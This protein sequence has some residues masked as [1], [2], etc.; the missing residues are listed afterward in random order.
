MASEAE[1]T[2]GS[3]DSLAR[4]IWGRIPPEERLEVLADAQAK[5]VQA[6]L[7]LLLMAFSVALGFKRPWIFF[8]SL[9]LAPFAFQIMSSKAWNM[10]KARPL[11]EY[12]AAR[13]T[14]RLFALNAGARS[15]EP[16]LMFRAELQPSV[17]GDDFDITDEELLEKPTAKPVWVSLF[18]DTIVIAA[19][20]P[21][22]ARLELAHSLFANFSITAEGFEEGD[23][24]GSKRLSIEVESRPGTVSRWTLDSRHPATLLACERR[25]KAYI[26]RH[27]RELEE[28]ER[29]NLERQQRDQERLIASRPRAAQIGLGSPSASAPA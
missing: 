29:R 1:K 10:A 15:V 16:A 6:A 19:E 23:E 17:A 27:Q 24:S 4:D 21:K 22:G 7:L 26:V 2:Q 13:A 12:A 11:L 9:L 3:K 14:A 20:G 8:S 18:A 5:G 25:A 28:Q